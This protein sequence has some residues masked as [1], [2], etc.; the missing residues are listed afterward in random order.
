MVPL[1]PL[2]KKRPGRGVDVSSRREIRRKV[3]L[4]A[5]SLFVKAKIVCVNRMQS[6]DTMQPMPNYRDV[7]D[8]TA[9][10]CEYTERTFLATHSYMECC[11]PSK[12][13]PHAHRHANHYRLRNFMSSCTAVVIQISRSHFDF[14]QRRL[15]GCLGHQSIRARRDT[16]LAKWLNARCHPGEEGAW[17]SNCCQETRIHQAGMTDGQ[18]FC[19]DDSDATK[20]SWCVR[21]IRKMNVFVFRWLPICHD[22]PT[23]IGVTEHECENSS[24][25]TADDAH[26]RRLRH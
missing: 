2:G 3:R 10:V 16:P 8:S 26:C 25:G 15:H 21:C 24:H 12:T 19:R 11:R 23:A 18:K 4:F 7:V 5:P 1:C 6:R 20:E 14:E 22:H 9:P 17:P 13:V